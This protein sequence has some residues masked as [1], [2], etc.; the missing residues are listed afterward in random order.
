[1]SNMWPEEYKK[2]L[3]SDI[4]LPEAIEY[5]S[6]KQVEKDFGKPDKPFSEELEVFK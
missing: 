4:S 3:E 5:F 1:M 6:T 2:Y